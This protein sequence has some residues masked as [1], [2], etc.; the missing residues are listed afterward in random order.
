MWGGLFLADF[1]PKLRLNLMAELDLLRLIGVIVAIW[2]T[3][4]VFSDS[5]S[6]VSVASG[7]IT[8]VSG[9]AGGKYSLTGAGVGFLVEFGSSETVPRL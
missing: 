3:R 4:S 9:L 6:K 5:V 8:S 7:S 1:L 2:E